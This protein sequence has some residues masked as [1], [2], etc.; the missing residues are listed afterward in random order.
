[1][2]VLVCPSRVVSCTFWLGVLCG[3][4]WLGL[5]WCRAPPLL[6]GA[7][8]RMCVCARAP[9]VPRLSWLGCAVRA[10]EP[11]SGPSAVARL[12]WLGCWGVCAVVLVPRLPPPFL[13]GR[14]PRGV[15]R[16]LPL[17]LGGGG[18]CHVLALWC[19][20]LAVLVS[21]LVVPV[22]LSPLFRAALLIF[23]FC[24]GVVCVR[25]FWVSLFPV[26]RCS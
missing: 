6:A 7:S 2:C 11:G 4:V 8:G 26:G 17:F 5:G 25:V 10:C 18:A 23:F 24:P 16:V 20:S 3:G 1:M 19:R 22:P 21:G 12:S 13:G 15:V 9:F 14:L